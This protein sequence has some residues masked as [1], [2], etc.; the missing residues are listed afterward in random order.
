MTTMTLE[1]KMLKNCQE[2]LRQARDEIHRLR[3]L[4]ICG[5]GDMFTEHDL[6]SCGNCV[7]AS[8]SHLRS[9]I[10]ALENPAVKDCLTTETLKPHNVSVSKGVGA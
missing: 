5:C 10:D 3:K 4:S 6:G 9:K 2:E 8:N 1:M 7:A